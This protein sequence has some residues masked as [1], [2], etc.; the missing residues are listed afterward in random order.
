MGADVGKELAESLDAGA[1]QVADKA[2]RVTEDGAQ[3]RRRAPQ[4]GHRAGGQHLEDEH[5]Q[6]QRSLAGPVQK[7]RHEAAKNAGHACKGAGQVEQVADLQRLPGLHKQ[8][9]HPRHQAHQH[10]HL[11]LEPGPGAGDGAAF[12]QVAPFF[13]LPDQA[14]EAADQVLRRARVGIAGDRVLAQHPTQQVVASSALGQ[15]GQRAQHGVADEAQHLAGQV[16]DEADGAVD[17]LAEDGAGA[18]PD[19]AQIGDVGH[20]QRAQE[21]AERGA[22]G[23]DHCSQGV[24]L[25]LQ[26]APHPVD[27]A[28]TLQRVVDQA[29]A[30]PHP[31]QRADQGNRVAVHRLLGDR[32]AAQDEA[33]QVI[34]RDQAGMVSH[35]AQ[36]QADDV[37]HRVHHRTGH[38][39]DRAGYRTKTA[40]Q[41]A[42]ERELRPG[43]AAAG[44][45]RRLAGDHG[46]GGA[47]GLVFQ[48]L[49][50]VRPAAGL[51]RAGAALLLQHMRH[52]V[53]QQGQV[54]GL[55]APA[56]Q[57]VGAIGQRAGTGAVHH[58]SRQRALVHPHGGQVGAQA[59]LQ[60]V[61]HRQ[62]Q[63]LAALGVEQRPQR[64][65]GVVDRGL[66][67]RLGA[68]SGVGLHRPGAVLRQRRSGIQPGRRASAAA[69]AWQGAGH[70]SA[71]RHARATRCPACGTRVRW[72]PPAALHSMARRRPA[73]AGWHAAPRCAPGR[74]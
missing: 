74:R 5:H 22:N 49:A 62:G 1:H 41:R 26:P 69:G 24:D 13:L 44:H 57:D 73:P 9:R 34:T 2:D 68:A 7:V 17:R 46:G 10:P 18:V 37:A 56:Q 45:H 65:G 58:R 61:A 50:S 70:V 36:R 47:V 55:L 23:A 8:P 20:A 67:Q 3:H 40:A 60:R 72:R 53:R 63:R 14:H 38:R 66:T 42:A 16:A 48:R 29:A 15:P 51:H 6:L 35:K 52:L 25:G 33:Q 59:A 71:R 27:D 54:G 21:A 19:A 32:V 64:G 4:D 11:G 39:A 30:G 43:G 12:L 31:H 28:V